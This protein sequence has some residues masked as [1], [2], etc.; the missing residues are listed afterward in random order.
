[1]KALNLPM[2]QATD[3]LKGLT[4]QPGYNYQPILADWQTL[5]EPFAKRLHGHNQVTDAYLLGLAVREGLILTT[6][7]KAILYLAGEHRNHVLV[8]EAK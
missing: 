1:M 4:E 8:L 2:Q 3:L 7:D 5:T 6:F